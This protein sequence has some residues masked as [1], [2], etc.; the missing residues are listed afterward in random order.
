M[1]VSCSSASC[2]S[3]AICPPPG[4]PVPSDTFPIATA[5]F[6]PT[7]SANVGSC[8]RATPKKPQ[9]TAL[10]P[11]QTNPALYL[12]M[13]VPN[14]T[15]NYDAPPTAFGFPLTIPASTSYLYQPPEFPQMHQ[16]RRVL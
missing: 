8:P 12:R 3:V 4:T 15:H 6:L 14:S 7:A 2:C 9:S 11:I 10:M 13:I 1:A 5:G 16:P